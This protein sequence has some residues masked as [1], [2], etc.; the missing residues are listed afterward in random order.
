MLDLLELLKRLQGGENAPTGVI[1]TA[2]PEEQP[3]QAQSGFNPLSHFLPEDPDKRDAVSMALLNAGAGMM[4]AGGPS[5]TPTN[6]LGVLGQGLGTG[7]TAYSQARKDASD[8]SVNRAKTRGEQV[9]LE[10][11]QQAQDFASTLGASGEGGYSISDLKRLYQQYLAMGEYSAANTILERIQ[12]LDDERRKDGMVMGE[13]GYELAPGVGETLNETERQ[14]SSGRVEGEEL[15]KK[16]DDIREFEYSQDN[17]DFA[18]RQEQLKKAGATNVTVEGNKIGTIPAGFQLVE[19]NG[20]T[21]LEPIPGSPQA[22]EQRIANDKRK[23]ASDVKQTYSD[24]VTNTIDDIFA[25]D[26]N[27]T[28]PT[29]GLLGSVTQDI[30]GTNSHDISQNLK[31]LKAN[32]S[33]ERLQ[34]MRDASPT[35][36]ALGGVSEK[37]MAL[38]ESSYAALEQSQSDEQFKRNLIRFHNTYMDVVH[39]RE[40][41]S[42][43]HRSIDFGVEQKPASAAGPAVGTIMTG[44]DGVQYRF[45]GG[46]NKKENW[47]P[48]L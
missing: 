44:S 43:Y 1:G 8:M 22:E 2:Q 32:A 38:L 33:F 3:Q 19:E 6:F 4:A 18:G 21:R 14:K 9:K 13:N 12:R 7:A 31:T 37:E 25:A 35:G 40:A 11:A 46:E 10:Q 30:P 16:T 34:A 5:T 41:G 42:Q 45:K 48:I 39:G 24:V 28:L 36:G 47:E 29:T 17:P 20:K 23:K 27:A 26:K 15:F